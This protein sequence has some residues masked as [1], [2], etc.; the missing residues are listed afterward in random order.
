MY[1][2]RFRRSIID[3]QLGVYYGNSKLRSNFLSFDVVHILRSCNMAAD[4]LAALG[5]GL[6][7]GASPIMDCIPNCICVLV[8]NDLVSFYE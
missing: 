7:P 4:G 3:A 8:A 1:E 6:S 2:L 5:A